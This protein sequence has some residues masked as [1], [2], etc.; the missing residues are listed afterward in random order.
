MKIL[1]LKGSRTF[2]EKFK[3][4]MISAVCLKKEGSLISLCFFK[5]GKII[6]WSKGF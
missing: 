2:L 4:Q 5:L 3:S 1:V 6:F